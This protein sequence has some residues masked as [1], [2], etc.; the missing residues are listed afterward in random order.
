M[1]AGD[2]LVTAERRKRRANERVVAWNDPMQLAVSK[3][4]D[5]LEGTQR[6]GEVVQNGKRAT[7]AVVCPEMCGVGCKDDRPAFRRYLKNLTARCVPTQL[8]GQNAGKDLDLAGRY[9][10]HTS[11]EQ[12]RQDVLDILKLIDFANL[13]VKHRRSS[14]IG[15]FL[16]MDPNLGVRKNAKGAGVIPMQMGHHKVGDARRLH[17]EFLDQ[18]IRSGMHQAT[19]PPG[20]LCREAGVH[21]DAAPVTADHPEEVVLRHRHIPIGGERIKEE[22]GADGSMRI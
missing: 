22:V 3:P 4:F 2:T 1:E 5:A 13:A 9:Y 19:T 16:G 18:Y 8:H 12:K 20:S 6:F 10:L 21:H 14:A 17:A 15:Q 7:S 11:I